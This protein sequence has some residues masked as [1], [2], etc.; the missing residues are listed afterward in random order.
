MYVI[1][2]LQLLKGEIYLVHFI[3]G[4]EKHSIDA[5]WFAEKD[6]SVRGRTKVLYD[7]HLLNIWPLR[8]REKPI[9]TKIVV[10]EFVRKTGWSPQKVYLFKSFL[11]RLELPGEF[12]D[13][14]FWLERLAGYRVFL[15]KNFI[16]LV[17]IEPYNAHRFRALEAVFLSH[18]DLKFYIEKEVAKQLRPEEVE[19]VLQGS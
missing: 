5:Y 15:N 2:S 14:N 19:Y 17:D 16:P 9:D 4:T 7:K 11:D 3:E 13:P 10:K 18:H 6:Y 8:I 12:Q 1:R